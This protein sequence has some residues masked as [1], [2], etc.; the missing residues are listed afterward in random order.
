[1][2]A[3]TSVLSMVSRQL[4]EMPIVI[5]GP[6]VGE[7]FRHNLPKCTRPAH[8]TSWTFCWGSS[9]QEHLHDPPSNE[10]CALYNLMDGLAELRHGFHNVAAVG[11]KQQT[12][13]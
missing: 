3:G 7:V 9:L 8:L 4:T 12:G 13:T 5:K 11:V 2:R 6:L 10:P 1:M